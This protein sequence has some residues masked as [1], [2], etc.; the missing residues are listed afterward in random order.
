MNKINVCM[1]TKFPPIQGGM[2]STAYWLARGLAKRGVDV[3]ILTNGNVVEREYCIAGAEVQRE[4][5]LDISCI[6]M[7]DQFIIPRRSYDMIIFFDEFMK[8]YRSKHIDVI[9]AHYLLPYGVVAYVLHKITGIPYILRHGGSDIEKFLK[10]GVYNELF[11]DVIKSAASVNTID[12]Y[13]QSLSSH[14]D[15]YPMFIPDESLF[16]NKNRTSIKPGE[17]IRIAYIGKVLRLYDDKDLTRM[18]NA[19]RPLKDKVSLVFLSQGAG[20]ENFKAQVDTSYVEFIDF[21]PPWKMPEFYKNIDYVLYCV[22][23]NPIPDWSNVVLEAFLSGVK[24]L[25]DNK[26]FFKNFTPFFGDITSGIMEID[27]DADPQKIYS[28]LVEDMKLGDEDQGFIEKLEGRARQA[29]KNVIDNFSE[30]IN[31]KDGSEERHLRFSYDEYIKQNMQFYIDAIAH[32][33]K[34]S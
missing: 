8:I 31:I 5:G 13:V 28:Q 10:K 16:N 19:F 21:I 2:S 34:E 27:L 18:V 4:D 14:Y 17:K 15:E 20:M 6:P 7:N 30:A 32:R 26:R 1:I 29:V 23:K 22:D 12:K 11:L 33:G 9:D 24:I 3:S 25:T